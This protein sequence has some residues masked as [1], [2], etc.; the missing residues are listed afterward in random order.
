MSEFLNFETLQVHAGRFRDQ[1]GACATPIHQTAA[2]LFNSTQHAADLF[3]LDVEGHIYTRLSNPT[4]DVFEKRIAALEG[5]VAAVAV[6]S[7]QA[8]QFLT[9][10]NIAGQGDNIVTSASLYGGTYNQFRV[11]YQNLGLTFRFV[12]GRGV[13]DYERLIDERTKAIFVESIGN[14]DFYIPDFD[15]LSELATKY[16][17]PLVVDN[18][19]GASGYLFRPFEHGA[20]IVT[21]AATKWIGGHGNAIAGVIVDGGNF[22]WGNGKFPSFTEPCDSYN[23]LVFWKKFARAAFAVRARTLGLRDWG[24]CLSPANAFLLLQGVETLSLRMERMMDNTLE[25]AKWLSVHPKVES[26]NYPGLKTSPNYANAKKYL[27]NGFGGVLTFTV[28]GDKKATSKVVEDL[29]LITHLVNVGDNKT[30]IAHPASTTHGQLSDEALAAA[31]IGAGTLRLAVGIEHI[32]DLKTD[33]NNAL[34]RI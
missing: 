9:F 24:C 8:S 26:V 31:G 2:Y 3:Q 17:I 21:H 23:G 32:D 15:A 1:F 27:K 11:S 29:E 20:N 6:S 34:N 5:G 33:L 30:L 13:E 28:K 14:S 22:D 19:F 12:Q 16:N 25:L 4:T 10:Q 18:T 7:G